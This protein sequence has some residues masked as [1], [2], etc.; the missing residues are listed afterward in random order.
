MTR[1]KFLKG[2]LLILMGFM[3]SCFRDAATA[4]SF[5]VGK[6]TYTSGQIT[7]VK[8]QQEV[9]G[10]IPS[11]AMLYEFD[12]TYDSNGKIN[13]TT[14]HRMLGSVQ[15]FDSEYTYVYD[16]AGKMTQ[17]LEKKKM[18]GIYTH[19]TNYIITHTGDNMTKIETV[20]GIQI[21]PVF[22][23]CLLQ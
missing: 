13:Y 12:L 8:Y 23:R 3:F 19:F 18:P 4:N 21:L 15:S 6:V 9:N 16:G 10:T 20:T 22:Q 5:L 1:H 2:V 11:N 14:C 7:K 17:I